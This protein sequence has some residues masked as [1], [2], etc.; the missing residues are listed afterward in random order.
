MKL[1]LPSSPLARQ[2]IG[3]GI[4]A[5]V[6]LMMYESYNFGSDILQALLPTTPVQAHEEYTDAT[7]DAKMDRIAAAAQEHLAQGIDVPNDG[8]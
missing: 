8:Q 6:A 5:L 1:S 2:I 3:A 4:G 7:R